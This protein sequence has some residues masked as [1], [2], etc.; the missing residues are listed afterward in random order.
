LAKI[1]AELCCF[2][3]TQKTKEKERIK[4]VL[5]VYQRLDKKAG[6]KRWTLNRNHAISGVQETL[7]H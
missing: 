4:S 5:N 2:Q 6:I 7:L 1:K 3:P